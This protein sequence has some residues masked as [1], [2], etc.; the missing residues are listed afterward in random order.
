MFADGGLVAD[1]VVG[2]TVPEPVVVG[3]ATWLPLAAAVAGTTGIVGSVG[4]TGTEVTGREL[5]VPV[6]CG[7]V[8]VPVG[9]GPV[10]DEP[11]GDE[12]VGDGL[13]GAGFDAV[14]VGAAEL[15]GGVGRFEG[16]NPGGDSE[17]GIGRPVRG[18]EDVAVGDGVAVSEGVT[19]GDGPRVTVGAPCRGAV[20]VGGGGTEA[21]IGG[22]GVTDG[23]LEARQSPLVLPWDAERG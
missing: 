16:G 17:L 9:D 14:V 4:V 18:S 21:G 22:A 5:A 10:G 1:W 3:G 15:V 19:L 8:G 2:G 13:V 6:G 12:P 23:V 11:V 7:T 20:L